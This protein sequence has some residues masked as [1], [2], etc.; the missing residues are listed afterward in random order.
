M[1]LYY[2]AGFLSSDQSVGATLA[3]ETNKHMS[4]IK[5]CRHPT[6]VPMKKENKL[7]MEMVMSGQ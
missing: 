5:E 6:I 4:T 1:K 2:S 3:R 7:S